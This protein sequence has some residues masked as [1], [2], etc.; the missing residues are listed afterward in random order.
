MNIIVCLK[1]IRHIYARTGSDLSVNYLAP[2]DVICRV[3]PYD[4]A[5]LSQAIK[6]KD[7]NGASKVTVLTL[8]PLFAENELN[9]SLALG[10]D[11]FIQIDT[12][13]SSE[14]LESRQ[15]AGLLARAVRETGAD[16][17]FCGKES[18]DRGN[19]QVGAFLANFLDLPFISSILEVAVVEDTGRVRASR[20]AGGGKREVYECDLPAVM[21]VDLC[22]NQPLLPTVQHKSRA[23][24]LPVQKLNYADQIIQSKTSSVRVFPPNP[25]PKKISA[26]KS[27]LPSFKRIRELLEGSQ[28]EKKGTMLTGSAESQVNAII[29]FLQERG[30]L[31]AQKENKES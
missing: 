15:K 19:G 1:P 2:E 9:R 4:E 24:Q 29:S 16:L 30:L 25:H 13:Q 26:P 17:V 8:G 14:Q 21:S 12:G 28:I 18:L 27:T 31:G 5:A 20:K 11:N 7:L 3:N 6:V 10:V 23:G 22:P